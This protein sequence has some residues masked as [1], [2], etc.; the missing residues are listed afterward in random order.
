MKLPRL[1]LVVVLLSL[2]LMMNG[3]FCWLTG[4]CDKT[5][6][7]PTSPIPG[8]GSSGQPTTLTL[9]WG[10]GD[11]PLGRQVTY[12]LYFGAANPPGLWEP[13]LTQKSFLMDSLQEAKTYYW[14]IVAREKNGATL[15]GAIWTFTTVYPPKSLVVDF[16][17]WATNWARGE[18]RTILWRSAYAGSQVKIDLYKSGHLQCHITGATIN[19]GYFDWL[20]T[21]CADHSD[22]DYIVRVTSL[23][24]TTLYAESDYFTVTLP[25]PIEMLSPQLREVW[26]ANESRTISWRPLGLG[27]NVKV[28]LHLYKGSEFIYIIAPVTADNGTF[29][30][31]VSDYSAGSGPDYRIRISDL[32]EF[33]CSQ[34]GD[35]F[36]IQAC[37]VLVA[38]PARD[39]VW[40]LGTTHTIVW[41]PTYLDQ[42]V[43]LEL[44]HAGDFVCTLAEDVLNTGNYDWIANRCE[45]IY[46]ENF[47]IRVL[48]GPSGA[49]GFSG[50]F[51]FHS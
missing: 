51:K 37:S 13:G 36:T 43:S 49:C 41:D 21:D 32:N 42:T 22:P 29:D 34:F 48:S 35:F 3:C 40:P 9:S 7:G 6:N 25:C 16:P 28:A 1:T 39:D 18:T 31:T 27:T 23:L 14:R 26:V 15:E 17:N 20:L 24:D 44:Y 4:N 12:D 2:A 19:D 38:S 33:N 8:D 50:K 11:S 30:W 46:G 5:L 45:S 10:G 47:Q